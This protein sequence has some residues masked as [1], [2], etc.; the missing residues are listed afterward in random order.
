M[1]MDIDPY[2][3]HEKRQISYD[4]S[5]SSS[6]ENESPDSSDLLAPI[7]QAFRAIE[8]IGQIV[9]NKYASVEKNKIKEMVKSV[10]DCG[11][12]TLDYFCKVLIQAKDELTEIVCENL[13]KKGIQKINTS[14]VERKTLRL[15]QD[16]SYVIC[17]VMIDKVSGFTF[18]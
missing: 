17:H 13:K 7:L 14:E 16:M 18:L 3:E 15:L 6:I 4:K 2:S 12:R 11:F 1:K 5:E 10:F 9:K 8:I